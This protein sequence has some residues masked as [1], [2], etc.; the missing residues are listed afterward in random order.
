MQFYIQQ[1]KTI[2]FV[3]LTMAVLETRSIL[4]SRYA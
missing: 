3:G 1:R 4:A 2:G